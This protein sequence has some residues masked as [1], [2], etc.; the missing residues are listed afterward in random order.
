MRIFA[1]DT[2]GPVAGV[3]LYEDGVLTHEIV[4]SHGLTHSQ[5]IMPMADD[6]LSAAGCGSVRGRGRAGL[7][8]RGAHRGVHGQGPGPRRPKALPGA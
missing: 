5:T 7:L 3:A 6:A 1:M 8:Y 2:S 4:A